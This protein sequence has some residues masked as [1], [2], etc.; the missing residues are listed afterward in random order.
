MRRKKMLKRVIVFGA[1]S[2]FGF[3]LCERL[4]SESVEVN[5]ILL[6]PRNPINKLMLD[7]RLLS[8]GRNALLQTMNGYERTG[9]DDM[10]DIIIHCCDDGVEASL[11]EQDRQNLIKSVELANEINVPYY[12]IT[13]RNNAEERLRKEHSKF[14]EDYL[15]DNLESCTT[16]QLPLLFGPFQ[17][18]TE[19]IP[20][21]LTSYIRCHKDVLVVDEPLL[22]IE[23]AVNAVYD[24]LEHLEVGNTYSFLPDLEKEDEYPM[25]LG[26]QMKTDDSQKDRN[27]KY[28]IKVPT[29]L[30]KGLKEQVAFIEKYKE[31]LNP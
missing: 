7:E 31:I 28:V 24:L 20:Q 29:S 19:S 21:F 23:D 1:H 12:F 25:S 2:Y 4:I 15:R 30:E 27:E 11:L 17:P 6:K 22:F 18:P 16:L 5:G 3:G 10:T 26:V 8:V 9:N 14:C 13:S